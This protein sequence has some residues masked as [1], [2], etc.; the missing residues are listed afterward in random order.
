MGINASFPEG[1]STRKAELRA[2]RKAWLE[3]MTRRIEEG[4][5]FSGRLSHLLAKIEHDFFRNTMGYRK[6]GCSI[7]TSDLPML[8]HQY[9]AYGVLKAARKWRLGDSYDA[10]KFADD[11][12]QDARYC[13]QALMLMQ[14]DAQKVYR[15][16]KNHKSISSSDEIEFWS[17]QSEDELF[18]SD[19]TV[20]EGAAIS[21]VMR[22]FERVAKSPGFDPFDSDNPEYFG[23]GSTAQEVDIVGGFTQAWRA[24]RIPDDEDRGKVDRL[25]AFDRAR[26]EFASSYIASHRDYFDGKRRPQEDVQKSLSRGIHRIKK[27]LYL[28]GGLGPEGALLSDEACDFAVALYTKAYQPQVKRV[29]LVLSHQR[30]LLDFA[31]EATIPTTRGARVQAE[32]WRSALSSGG[33]D[34]V[35]AQQIL[36]A[37]SP[38]ASAIDILHDV[39]HAAASAMTRADPDCVLWDKCPCH[40]VK[41][42]ELA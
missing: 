20:T 4:T 24:R 12:A 21:I 10:G 39:E 8:P 1:E 28:L 32:R 29:S 26:R 27:M 5:L 3:P 14:Q 42:E 11:P 37:I 22:F 17:G 36:C 23:V 33:S 30:K 34:A 16:W 2:N 15:Y 40:S 41:E 9:L 7:D 31:T 13:G 38:S 6:M 19:D 25:T 18:T 35:E